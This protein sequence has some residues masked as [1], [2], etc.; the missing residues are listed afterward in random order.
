[1][2]QQAGTNR[3]L[4]NRAGVPLVAGVPDIFQRELDGLW[5]IGWHHGAVG[6][7]ESR[8]FAAAVA[9]RLSISR[10]QGL[11]GRG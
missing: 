4:S 5:S 9:A 7:F 10:S 8:I 6:P 3:D 1:M 2:P 11:W